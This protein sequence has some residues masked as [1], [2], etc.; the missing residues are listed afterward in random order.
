[1]IAQAASGRDPAT[2]HRV[3]EDVLAQ[4]D[5]RRAGPREPSW[6]ERLW[7][8][9]SEWFSDHFG[10]EFGG[11]GGQVLVYVLY[12]LIALLLLWLLFT[13]VRRAALRRGAAEEA[14]AAARARRVQELLA[15][16]REARAKG[17]FADA[18]RFYAWALVV[19]LSE[20]GDLE[21][22]DAWTN[23]EL[24]ERGRPRPEALRVLAPLVPELDAKSFGHEPA[25]EADVERLERLCR[26]HLGGLA[27]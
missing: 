25:L 15:R 12:G 11:G 3:V 22:R 6:L 20:R 24:V 13:F 19:G 1:M 2:I 9:I 7:E 17:T 5:Y 4:E 21:Y 14:P 27:T 23:R 18:L 10:F 26:E 16:A 8:R